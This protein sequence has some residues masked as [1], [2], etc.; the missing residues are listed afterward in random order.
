MPR[1]RIAIYKEALHVIARNVDAV[2]IEGLD[3]S[4]FRDRYADE[5]HE[6]IACFLHLLEKLD[7]HAHAHDTDL[8]VIADEHPTARLAQGELRRARHEPVWGFR[9]EP[10]RIVD[11]VYF[12]PSDMSRLIQAVDL[13]AFLHQRVTDTVERDLRATAANESLWSVLAPLMTASRDRTWRPQ[14]HDS[15]RRGEG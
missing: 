15:P 13:V 14:T 6:H 7:R 3:R 8:T 9:G 10:R 2:F 1:A 12:V 4:L 11:T 5:H